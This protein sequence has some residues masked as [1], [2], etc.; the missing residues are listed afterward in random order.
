MS[1]V[2]H[3]TT[4]TFE[5]LDLSSASAILLKRCGTAVL[6][7]NRL[8]AVRAMVHAA[9]SLSHALDR[10]TACAT[11]HGGGVHCTANMNNEVSALSEALAD[12]TFAVRRA[13][14]VE[15]DCA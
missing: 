4:E 6:E 11:S 10:F 2:R 3:E 14:S 13:A 5:T 7:A 1:N 8:A 9:R 12:W 15:R